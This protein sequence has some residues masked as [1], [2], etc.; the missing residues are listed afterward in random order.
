MVLGPIGSALGH[1]RR[2]AQATV[3]EV[4]WIGLHGV[5]YPLGLVGEKT[6]AEFARYNLHDLHPAQRGLM[7]GDVVAAGTP[8]LLVHGVVDNRSVFT[9][10]RRGL[11]RRGFNHV[12]SL[13]Y[14]PLTDDI[15]EV[16][17]QLAIKVEQICE[18]TGYERIHLIGH[19]MGGVIARYYVQ[20]MDGDERVDTCVTLGSPH[21]GTLAARLVPH[22]LARQLRPGSD[23][24][25]EL[26]EPAPGI[27]TRFVA[28]WSDHDQM[29]IPTSS[30]RLDHPDLTYRNV[31]VRGV[32]HISLPIDGRVVHE[33]GTTLAH[34]DLEGSTIAAPADLRLARPTTA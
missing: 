19:S 34:L 9:V 13:N 27:R 23:L 22:P 33:I 18:E 8:I 26:A 28:I 11:R 5:M 16:A 12:A 21:S 1:V 20:C 24:I 14:S 7:I 3:V 31:F 2:A 32:G 6:R 29:V 10:L 25:Q 15:R 17:R 30:A 4:T